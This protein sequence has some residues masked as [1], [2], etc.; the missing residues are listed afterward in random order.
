M[1][2]AVYLIYFD[3]AGVRPEVIIGEAAARHRFEQVSQQ[4]NAHLFGKIESNSRDERHA[5]NNAP[6]PPS[7]SGER[8][9][10]QCNCPGGT[11]APG[12]HAPNCPVRERNAVLIDP[13]DGGTWVAPSPGIDAA[14]QKPVGHVARDASIAH[15]SANLPEGTP[16][17]AAPPAA[18]PDAAWMADMER[19]VNEHATAIATAAKYCGTPYQTA[20]DAAYAALLAHLRT[21]PSTEPWCDT[22]DRPKSKCGCPDCGPSLIDLGPGLRNTPG[23]P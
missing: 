12:L 20:K 21:K 2:K 17:Y 23:K 16:L 4:W 14:E 9:T 7:A 13:Y 1:D 5:A 6:Q 19:L 3:D 10:V 8:E 22:M 18:Q 11:K 15:M